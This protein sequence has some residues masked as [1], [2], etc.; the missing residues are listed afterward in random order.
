MNKLKAFSVLFCLVLIAGC[1][2]PKYDHVIIN[3]SNTILE[4]E[5]EYAEQV[6]KLTSLQLS[7]PAR[8]SWND[9]QKAE[10]PSE[11]WIKLAA[12]NEYQVESVGI[13]TLKDSTA[14]EKIQFETK[15]AKLKLLPNEV[16]RVF[17]SSHINFDVKNVRKIVLRGENGKLEIE[18]AG[19]EQFFNHCEGGFF[20]QRCDY[21][22][23]Y[24]YQ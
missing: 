7:N 3:Q 6:G 4:V 12:G 5:Y 14:T 22:I 11:K 13:E 1:S 19:F 20:S 24:N 9:Y 10:A 8:M 15:K 16:L 21:R 18:G 17:V 23:V 2:A